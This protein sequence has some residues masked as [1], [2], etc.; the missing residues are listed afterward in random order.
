MLATGHY[1]LLR[2][3]HME[4]A[5]DQSGV[6]FKVSGWRDDSVV[7]SLLGKYEDQSS[8]SSTYGTGAVTLVVVIPVLGLKSYRRITWSLPITCRTLGSVRKATPKE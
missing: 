6:Y 2:R 5:N 3:G 8:D 1:P 4:K 7:K